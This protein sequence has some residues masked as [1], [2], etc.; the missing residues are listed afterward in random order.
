MF[1]D[2]FQEGG[3]RK[4]VSFEEQIMSKYKYQ[5]IFLRQIE[6]IVFFILQKNFLQHTRF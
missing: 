2:S 5:S 3:L 6:T 1:E 4:T